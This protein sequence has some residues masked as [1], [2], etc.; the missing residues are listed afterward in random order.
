MECVLK[1]KRG[2]IQIL[3]KNAVKLVLGY[4]SSRGRI[5]NDSLDIS[6]DIGAGTEVGG[7]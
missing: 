6:G 3:R 5:P 4:Y 7:P 2:K 1:K